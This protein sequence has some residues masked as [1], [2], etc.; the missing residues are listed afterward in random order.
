MITGRNPGWESTARRAMWTVETTRSRE[1][2]RGME[3]MRRIIQGSRKIRALK[4][5]TAKEM[6]PHGTLQR[7]TR[8]LGHVGTVPRLGR[9]NYVATII[10]WG[11][12]EIGV[13]QI[14][15]GYWSY[16]NARSNL[17]SSLT[18]LNSDRKGSTFES[19]L[20]LHL[21]LVQEAF[22][23][24]KASHELLF[25]NYYEFAFHTIVL[26]VANMQRE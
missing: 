9:E 10:T 20:R 19:V 1:W 6:L 17:A 25:I 4:G 11:N 3:R 18:L 22:V 13:N 14:W 24:F 5:K 23:S 26:Q 16:S 15:I 7:R 2:T 12:F 8:V 21:L